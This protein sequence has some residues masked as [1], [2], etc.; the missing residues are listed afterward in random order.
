MRSNRAIGKA[1]LA[2]QLIFLMAQ[3]C[4]V[5]AAGP[6]RQSPPV[7]SRFALPPD[8]LEQPFVFA[9][10]KIPLDRSDVRRRIQYEVNFLLLDARSVLTSWLMNINRYAWIFREIFAK[11]GIPQEFALLAPVVSG[12]DPLSTN[13]IPGAGWW[14]LQKKCGPGE[15]VLMSV[16]DW[17][18]DRLDLD[19]ST[20]CFAARLKE[21]RKELP[22]K[23]WITAAAAYVTTPKEFEERA[24]QWNSDVF[25]D[26]PLP[27]TAESLI[28]RWIALGIIDAG[29]TTFGIRVEEAKPLA[30]DQ[31]SGL[32]LARDLTVAE[33][34][35]MTGTSPLRI[36]RLNP[37]IIPSKG[38][39]PATE[40]RKR[41]MHT[42]AVPRGKGG[43]LVQELKKARYLAPRR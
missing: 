43:A 16:D 19:L 31:V 13:R 35:K 21:I 26:L 2:T 14:A 3:V 15:G 12:L 7:C 37:K 28:P 41:I 17:H 40:K 5:E 23:S 29:R 27:E 8:V 18:D 32:V 36:L 34:A 9:G 4:P 30:F 39:F 10:E 33:I 22:T 1:L 11:Q 6:R 25:W 20:R 38:I 42:L 24:K